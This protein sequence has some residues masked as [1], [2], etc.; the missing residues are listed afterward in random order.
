MP[1]RVA[2][3]AYPCV[4]TFSNLEPPLVTY[5]VALPPT[6]PLPPIVVLM[7]GTSGR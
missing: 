2:C 1:V 3:I 5:N 6:E 7:R 4:L